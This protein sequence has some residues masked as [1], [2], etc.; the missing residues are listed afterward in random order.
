MIESI[1]SSLIP[2][3]EMAPG[4]QF[5][6]LNE[7]GTIFTVISFIYYPNGYIK[8]A[9]CLKPGKLYPAYFSRKAMVVKLKTKI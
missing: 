9:K 3:I 2:V 6:F 4:D 1:P 8:Y 5:Y 7:R